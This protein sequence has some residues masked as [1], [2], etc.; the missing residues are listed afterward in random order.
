MTDEEITVAALSD[1]DAQPLTEEQLKRMRRV[2]FVKHVRWKLG[3]SQMEFAT[4]FD[5]PVG[6]LR[7]WEQG[8][9][10]PDTTVTAYLRVIAADPN[11]VCQALG[12]T[13]DTST[14]TSAAR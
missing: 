4:R 14:K 1:P 3:L 8:R 7:D 11:A 13:P 6:T 2:P 5:I 10:E 9:S 12:K